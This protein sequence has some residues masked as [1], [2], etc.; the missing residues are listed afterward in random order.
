MNKDKHYWDER[1]KTRGSGAGSC[2]QILDFKFQEIRGMPNVR[3][4]LDVGFGDLNTILRV[5]SFFSTASY[6]G[7]DISTTA[8]QKAKAKKLDDR[9]NFKLIENSIFSHPSDL[10]LC[11]DVLYHITQD[12]DYENMLRSLKQSWKKHLFLTVYKDECVNQP[13]AS[14]MKI[15]KFDPTYF[16]K[17]YKKTLIPFGNKN[18]YLFQFWKGVK[19]LKNNKKEILF[20]DFNRK[21]WIDLTLN[22]DDVI[23][24]GFLD[25]GK[26]FEQSLLQFVSQL[27]LD[28]NKAIV[29]IGAN[30]GNH[31]LFFS[32]FC[33]YSKIFAFEPYDKV[34]NVLESHIK[35]NSLKNVK[36][37]PVAVGAKAGFCDLEESPMDSLGKKRHNGKTFVKKGNSIKMVT[38]DDALKNEPISLIKMDVEG[39]EYNVLLGARNILK[40][41]HPYLFIEAKTL[42]AKQQ[43]DD[44]LFPLGYDCERKL[45]TLS[46]TYFYRYKKSHHR[47]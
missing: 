42:C 24:R 41:Q 9:F 35:M 4:I 34:R 5:T 38:L 26:F 28:E 31:T 20:K 22:D 3:S 2:G 7:L 12:E 18:I 15:R 27:E 36:V 8:L 25:C 43:I 17:Q 47:N 32:L 33:L 1:Y 40:K 13:V 14:H 45:N 19:P 39:Y 29:D 44:Y 11:L 23:S 46:P 16:S 37:F 10:V 21:I 30:V 6:L